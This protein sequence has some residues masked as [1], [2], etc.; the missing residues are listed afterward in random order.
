MIF[1]GTSSN[2]YSLIEEINRVQ[3]EIGRLQYK[4]MLLQSQLNTEYSKS[5]INKYVCTKTANVRFE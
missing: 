4:L 2:T 5:G 3:S 1:E